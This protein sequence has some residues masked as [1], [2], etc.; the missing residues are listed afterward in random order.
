MCFNLAISGGRFF[1]SYMKIPD[2]YLSEL[3]KW[4]DSG[5]LL[6]VRRNRR[7]DRIYCPFQVVVVIETGNL[8]IGQECYVDEVKV[9]TELDNVYVIEGKSYFADCFEILD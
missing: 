3:S 2:D 5:S 6:V 1:Y 7:L 8:E 9:S 4:V